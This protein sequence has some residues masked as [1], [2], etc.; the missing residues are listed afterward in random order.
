MRLRV[1]PAMTENQVRNGR[2]CCHPEPTTVILNL[3]QDLV[4]GVRDCGSP[5]SG[6]SVEYAPQEVPLGDIC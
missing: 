5:A 1:K 4:L 6:I 2:K 3:I